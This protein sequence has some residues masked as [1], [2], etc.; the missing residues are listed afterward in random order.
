MAKFR[1]NQEKPSHSYLN[2]LKKLC[3]GFYYVDRNFGGP[4]I[5]RNFR[6]NRHI[7]DLINIPCKVSISQDIDLQMWQCNQIED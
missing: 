6:K 4:K 7:S 1:K 2:E 5:W 3:D